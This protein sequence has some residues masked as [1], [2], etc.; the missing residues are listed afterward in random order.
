[1]YATVQ[2]YYILLYS[3]RWIKTCP[4]FVARLLTVLIGK[5][6]MVQTYIFIRL[7]IFIKE[8]MYYWEVKQDVPVCIGS[9]V[10]NLPSPQS[11][12]EGMKDIIK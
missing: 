7:E 12:E 8:C 3:L 9:I 6:L 11:R 1:M 4:I 10:N 5:E 2:T